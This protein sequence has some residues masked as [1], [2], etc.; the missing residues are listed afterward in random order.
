MRVKI[1]GVL[2]RIHGC[3]GEASKRQQAHSQSAK[4]SQHLNR[5]VKETRQRSPDSC[6]RNSV[7]LVDQDAHGVRDRSCV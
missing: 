7:D 5:S 6:D 1:G 2:D 4:H 3:C